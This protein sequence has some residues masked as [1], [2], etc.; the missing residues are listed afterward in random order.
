MES[1]KS[2]PSLGAFALSVIALILVSVALE[3]AQGL[4][5][6][7]LSAIVLGVV[8]APFADGL[9][10]MR[11][12]STASA[13]LIML[14]VLGLAS[15]LFVAMG[16][17]VNEAIDNAP[18]IW[19]ELRSLFE[20]FR[21][22]IAGVQEIQDTV[23]EVLT[24]GEQ[25]TDETPA[26]QIPN[27]MDA[28][29]YGPSLLSGALIF[30][31]TLY[32]FLSTRH[33]IYARLAR[34]VPALSEDLL[35]RAEARV[36]KYFLSITVVNAGFGLVIMAAMSA[37]GMPQPVMWGIATFLLNFLLYLG[38]ALLA[39]TLLL[40]GVMVF[41]GAMSFAPMA[42]F[43][44]CNMVEAQFVTPS[45]VGRQMAVNPLMIFLSLIFWLWLWGPIGGLVAI[46]ILVWT[47]FVLARG[48]EPP[49]PI[50]ET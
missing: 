33:D 43:V 19:L 40:V 24:D 17:T 34:F 36:S 20:T 25:T 29:S 12:P 41:D 10:K 5:A 44:L 32:F 6:P 9:E 21:D 18:L 42:V 2:A 16:P 30:A 37:L 49:A 39:G 4:V 22:A 23:T 28:L 13:L 1:N 50:P 35:R 3:M 48:N 11:I 26:V 15:V 47:R 31:G 45:I 46:P 27:V 7:V 8:L 14:T 38:P